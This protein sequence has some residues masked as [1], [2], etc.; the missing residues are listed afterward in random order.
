MK[1]QSPVVAQDCQ[2]T[3]TEKKRRDSEESRPPQGPAPTNPEQ[4]PPVLIT[5]NGETKGNKAGCLRIGRQKEKKIENDP[6][7]QDKGVI[8]G[9]G[10]FPE[11]VEEVVRIGP[12]KKRLTKKPQAERPEKEPKEKVKP[13][14]KNATTDHDPSPG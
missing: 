9:Q 8:R 1:G 11:R 2:K 12:P 3:Q 14:G 10:P 13:E 6:E 5:D 7:Q 4:F